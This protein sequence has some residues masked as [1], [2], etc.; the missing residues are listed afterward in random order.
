MAADTTE[1]FCLFRRM[2]KGMVLSSC[3]PSKR[4]V[5]YEAIKKCEGRNCFAIFRRLFVIL[6]LAVSCVLGIFTGATPAAQASV[7]PGNAA[8]NWAESHALG[9]WYGWGG[10]GPSVFDCSGTVYAAALHAD[11]IMLPRTTYSM[12]GSWHLVPIPV[13]QA[14]RGDLLFFGSG[15]VEFATKW[16]HWSFGAQQSGTRVGWH[17]WSGWWA[18]TMAFRLR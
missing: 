1:T 13:S 10:V 4:G 6:M 16:Y 18:P 11:N 15:H 14:Q 8:L 9:H 12:I 17:H 3:H 7:S 2:C 5:M